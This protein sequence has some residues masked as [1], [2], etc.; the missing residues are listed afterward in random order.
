[1]PR[2]RTLVLATVLGLA[3]MVLFA[4]TIVGLVGEAVAAL[5][6]IGLAVRGITLTCDAFA[7]YRRAGS[8]QG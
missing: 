6:L 7:Q 2:A 1:M 3:V 8:G 4:F 5:S